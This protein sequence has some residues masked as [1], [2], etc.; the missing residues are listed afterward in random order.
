M[1]AAAIENAGDIED[2]LLGSRVIMLQPRLGY[3]AAVDPVLLAATVPARDGERVLDLG[4]GVGAVGLCLAARVGGLTVDGLE[5]QPRLAALARGNFTRNTVAGV[6]HAGDLADPPA[7]LGS[8]YAHVVA[9]PPFLE[10]GRGTVS[11]DAIK[12][13]ADHEGG[14]DLNAWA[15]FA[16]ARVR[17]RGTVTM[18]HRADR[19]DGVLAAYA[20]AGL[21]S[22][23]VLPLWP[24]ADGRPA[25]RVLVQGRRSGRAPLLLL[26]GLVL[27]A[28][29]GRF[30]READAVLRD[31]AA[32]PMA[33]PRVQ[34]RAPIG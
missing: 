29:D 15:A 6:V 30:T 22:L 7:D 21:G 32:L 27:H 20:A 14:A 9:N 16:A 33:A 10:E 5:I 31:A 4:C 12:Q 13:V 24:K 1:Q 34:F 23:A 25:K 26:P 3:R 8:D 17:R 2:R 11:P 19:L 28:A 18:I